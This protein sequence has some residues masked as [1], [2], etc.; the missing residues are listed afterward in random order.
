MAPQ[1]AGLQRLGSS[2]SFGL[3]IASLFPREASVALTRAL[4]DGYQCVARYRGQEYREHGE[5][6]AAAALATLGHV[7]KV[8]D[9][10][11]PI[12]ADVQLS[13]PVPNA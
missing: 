4:G 11:A 12:D 13:L 9:R 1:E 10:R 8:M 7:M 6:A 5:T 3:F 2:E